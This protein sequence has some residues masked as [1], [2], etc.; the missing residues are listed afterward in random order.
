WEA[1]GLC[2]YLLIG[3]WYEK[4]SAAAAGKKAFLVNRIGDFGFALGLF[5]LWTVYGTLDFH[6]TLVDG[7]LTN[8]GILGQTMLGHPELYV[9]GGLA[10]AICLLLF[11]GACGKSAQFPLH[12]WLPD[13]MEGPTPVSALIHAATMVTAGVYMVA[14]CTPLFAASA[15]ARLVVAVVGGF[16][17]LMAA[18]IALAQNDLKRIMAY[19]TVSQLGYMFLGLGV[20]TML[21]ITAGM[22]HLFTHAFFKA[23]LFL[24]AGSVMHAMAGV[25]DVR[26]LGGL[27]HKLPKTYWLFLVGGLTLAGLFPLSG[28]WSKDAILAAVSEHAAA[29]GAFASWYFLLYVAALVTAGLTAFYVTRAFLLTFHGEPK[30]SAKIHEHAHESPRAMTGPMLVL[31][32]AAVVVGGYF[33]MTHGFANFLQKTPS[34]EYMEDLATTGNLVVAATHGAAE[35]ESG[36]HLTVAVLSTVVALGGIVLALALYVGR[37]KTLAR[38][39][40]VLDHVG[41]HWVVESKFFFD[42]IYAALFVRPLELLAKCCAQFDREGIDGMVDLIGAIP[43]RLGAWLRPLQGGVVS[44]YALAM[45][46]GTLILMGVLMM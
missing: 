2:S 29:G 42:E 8:V 46:L 4:P 9:G 14:R 10:T 34:I 31:A 39:V 19:S 15:D 24:A 33:E 25:I 13:A 17:A 40:W 44:Y 28:F 35:A 20:G 45:A 6:D 18:V 1:V 5:L 12:V 38:L 43:A 30:G 27:R 32:V 23:L 22:F 37:Q 26:Q 36:G 11:L 16:T 21:G 41:L 7:Q 3:F